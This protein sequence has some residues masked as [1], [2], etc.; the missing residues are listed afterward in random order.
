[1]SIWQ[2]SHLNYDFAVFNVLFIL[3]GTGISVIKI[4]AILRKIDFRSSPV[5]NFLPIIMLYDPPC[6]E[7]TF[8]LGT[9]PFLPS[10]GNKKIK[11]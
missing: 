10:Q 11:S 4:I 3:K 9:S 7:A 5:G 2:N 8:D 1:L 6:T